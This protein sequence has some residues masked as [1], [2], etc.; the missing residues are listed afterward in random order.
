MPAEVSESSIYCSMELAVVLDVYVLRNDLRS[1]RRV[2]VVEMLPL[3]CGGMV[4]VQVHKTN[5]PQT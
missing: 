4:I 1:S 2:V 3:D 5:T